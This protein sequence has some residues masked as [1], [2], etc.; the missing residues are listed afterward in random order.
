MSLRFVLQTV[1]L[2][3]KIS[4]KTKFVVIAFTVHHEHEWMKKNFHNFIATIN[5]VYNCL[6]PNQPYVDITLVE[7]FSKLQTFLKSNFKVTDGWD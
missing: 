2:Y 7:I 1:A 5:E 6:I 4:I 3:K